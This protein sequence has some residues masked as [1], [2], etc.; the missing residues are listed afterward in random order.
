MRYLVWLVR[1]AVFVLLLGFAAKNDQTVALKF[2]LGHEWQASLVL[3]L[4]VFFSA[5]VLIGVLA[6]SGRLLRLRHEL[7]VVKREQQLKEKT[8]ENNKS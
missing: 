5:G 1:L 2:F 6:M 7:S 3:M 8:Q 4:L